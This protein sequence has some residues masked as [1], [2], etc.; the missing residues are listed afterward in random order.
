MVI[1]LAI[2]NE[3]FEYFVLCQPKH[4]DHG[5]QLSSIERSMR[6]IAS[7]VLLLARLRVPGRVHSRLA[8]RD[9]PAPRK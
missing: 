8:R 1:H 5:S 3:Y 4:E 7:L 2:D 6:L 9:R